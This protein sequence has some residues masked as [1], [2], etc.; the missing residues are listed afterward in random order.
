MQVTLTWHTANPAGRMPRAPLCNCSWA[1][2]GPRNTSNWKEAC[3]SCRHR[4]AVGSPHGRR[5]HA[6][7]FTLRNGQQGPEHTDMCHQFVNV[8][9][10]R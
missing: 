10:L 9:L 6:N 2:R 4:L 3:C 8:L 5:V 1:A 7:E